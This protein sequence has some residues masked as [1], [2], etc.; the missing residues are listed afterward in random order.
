[1]TLLREWWY[2]VS[3]EAGERQFQYSEA[4]WP[5]PGTTFRSSVLTFYPPTGLPDAGD[6][7]GPGE[8]RDVGQRV[9]ADREDVG[10]EAGLQ[11]A[12]PGRL[13]AERERRGRGGCLDGLQRRHPE[14]GQVHHLGTVAA[15]RVRPVRA[16]DADVGPA[17]DRHP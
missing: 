8:H 5:E 4:T 10:V 3:L 1:M 14:L 12:A 9:R 13:R 11:L 15:P 17:R 7:L 2:A 6:V 16:G